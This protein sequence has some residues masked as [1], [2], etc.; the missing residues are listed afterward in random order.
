MALLLLASE[1]IFCNSVVSRKRKAEVV[2]EEILS[3]LPFAAGI[4][5][6][7]RDEGSMDY[8]AKYKTAN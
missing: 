7:L 1:A 8:I 3:V 5:F 6:V 4:F 2:T